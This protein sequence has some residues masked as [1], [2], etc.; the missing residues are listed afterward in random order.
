MEWSVY[1][2]LC[3][4]GSLYTGISKDVAARFEQHKAGRGAKYFRG[5]SPEKVVYQESRLDQTAALQREYAIKQLS[6]R[7]KWQLIQ[8]VPTS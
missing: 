4:D 1:M 6:C 8:Q 2:I 3:S 7:Q 5:R